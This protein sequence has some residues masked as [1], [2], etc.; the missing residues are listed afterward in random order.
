MIAAPSAAAV[1]RSPAVL[2]AQEEQQAAE[3]S[4]SLAV[5]GLTRQLAKTKG[6]DYKPIFPTIKQATPHGPPG[7]MPRTGLWRCNR[8][9]T[10]RECAFGTCKSSQ[11]PERQKNSSPCPKNHP[12][13]EW[14]K[15]EPYK[16]SYIE[17]PPV[18]RTRCTKPPS[19][20]STVG[21]VTVES[22]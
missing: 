15:A 4:H 5:W 20:A 2:R 3:T 21:T 10:C 11:D 1:R 13:P 12:C 17:L 14:D 18:A 19:V 6:P 9:S 22:L 8:K 7:P 16:T